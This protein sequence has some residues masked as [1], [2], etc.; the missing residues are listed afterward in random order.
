MKILILTASTGGG[1]KRAAAAIEAKIHTL[2]PETEVCVVDGMK[3]VG[4]F[5]DKTVCKGYHIMATKTPEIYGKL[6]RLSDESKTIAK[7]VVKSNEI[8]ADYLLEVIE[9]HNPDIIIICHAFIT[10]MVSYLKGKNMIHAKVISLITDYDAHRTYVSPHIDAFVIAVPEMKR[11]L[12]EEYDV[13]EDKIYPLGIPT[14]DRFSVSETKEELCRRERLDP[15][16]PIVL[17]MAGSFGVTGVLDFYEQLAQT[18]DR[19]QMVVITGRNIRLFDHLDRK[20]QELGTGKNTKL[21]YFVDNVEDYM[22]IADLIVTKPGGLTVTESIACHLPMVIYSAFPGQEA[23]N[24]DFLL[25]KNAA[26]L[27]DKEDG[28]QEILKL[29]ESPERLEEMRENCKRLALPNAAED[30]FRLACKLYEERA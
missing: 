28:A 11:K 14:F 23:D 13:P 21:L 26:V 15:N 2:S 9:K 25:R 19:L 1:H 27:V 30:I 10:N 7:V 3:A 29:L 20:I 22:H 12:C 4:K 17:M 16:R 24:V 18:S 8:M 5:Y 6:Y